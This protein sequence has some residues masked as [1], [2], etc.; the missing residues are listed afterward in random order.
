MARRLH[1]S[2]FVRRVWM[3]LLVLVLSVSGVAVAADAFV[4]TQREQVESFVE[5]VSR[6][7]LDERLD[8][9][10]AYVDPNV[11]RCRL[12]HAGDTR[13]FGADEQGE[14]AEAIR[15]ALSVFDGS[16]QRLLQH[17]ERVDGDRAR[18][19]VRMGDSG[20]EQTVI[21]DLV[22][23]GDRWLVRAVRTL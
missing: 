19:T 12:Q 21:Y 6:P 20:Y 16:D 17:A 11:I 1:I 23:S 4:V 15:G 8:G 7:R 14:T 18:V 2:R 13:E 5:A 22:R 10:L 3:P 9:V